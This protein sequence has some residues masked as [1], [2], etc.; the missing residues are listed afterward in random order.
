VGAGVLPFQHQVSSDFQPSFGES[1]L[2]PMAFLAAQGAW[3]F[4]R[5]SLLM[6][7]RG[8]YGPAQTER[9]NAQLGGVGASLG[10]RYEP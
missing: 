3:R 4:S 2:A 9:L 10:V 6:E 5:V 7:L 1:K 8:E